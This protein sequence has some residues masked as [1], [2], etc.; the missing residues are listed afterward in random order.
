MGNPT[1]LYARSARFLRRTFGLQ[2]NPRQG[3]CQAKAFTLVHACKSYER[4]A[5]ELTVN[6]SGYW[7]INTKSAYYRLNAGAWLPVARGA[8]RVPLELFLV[9]LPL[10][11]L[12]DGENCIEFE[13]SSN[14]GPPQRLEHRFH[15]E[16]AL[17]TLPFERHWRD[18][19][20]DVSDGIWETVEHSGQSWV[21]PR[22]GCEDYD[23]L[24]VVGG[25]FPAS[26]RVT[27]DV[28]FRGRAGPPGL[29]GF[30]ICTL[31]GGH[32]DEPGASPRHG[33]LYGLHWYYSRC[34]GVGLEFSHRI[35]KREPAWT[36]GYR[37]FSPEPGR[38]YQLTTEVW[39][40]QFSG[41][42]VCYRQRA[43]WSS[44]D[45]EGLSPWIELVDMNGAPLPVRDYAVA[46]L[47][48][49]SQVEFGPVLV[50]ALATPSQG[51]S[52]GSES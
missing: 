3:A 6:L 30:G 10:H 47:A 22:P 4:R 40:E 34:E 41:K 15:Y 17:P 44:G 43:K 7:G 48:H 39:P 26:R 33:W 20:L 38:R 31:W 9:E 23:R 2:P 49:R 35:G 19:E 21:R 24:L 1:G 11:E 14:K 18:S 29:F 5:G 12:R 42:H 8:P 32:P 25:A 46:L 16:D 28:I 51:T 27:V 52:P 13:V 45:S 50:E 37:N 36:H